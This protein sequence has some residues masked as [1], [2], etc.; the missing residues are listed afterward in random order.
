MKKQKKKVL[1]QNGGITLIA[2]IISVIILLILAGIT[3]L[4]LMGDNGILNN[5][6]KAAD[7]T[8][9]E[10]VKEELEMG[11]TTCQTKYL[12]EKAQDG[13]INKADYF[14]EEK[15]NEALG[16]KGKISE[17]TIDEED[18]TRVGKYY[19]NTVKSSYVFRIEEDGKVELEMVISKANIVL[20]I[21][22]GTADTKALETILADYITGT[23]TWE[24][25]D[26]SVAT[27]D[28][29]GLVT[30]VAEGTTEV[31]A[32]CG[33]YSSTCGITVRSYQAGDYIEYDVPYTDVRTNYNFTAT[34]GWRF[35]GADSDGNNLL[36]STGIPLYMGYQCSRYSMSVTPDDVKRLLGLED[37]HYRWDAYSGYYNA[38]ALLEKFADIEF[39][40]VEF[41][42]DGHQDYKVYA[43]NEDGSGY[44]A[45]LG[46]Y[47]NV[48]G[49][50]SGKL[51]E[52]GRNPL[53]TGGATIVRA[54]TYDEI[55][56][57]SEDDSLR[58]LLKLEN[59]HSEFGYYSKYTFNVWGSYFLAT[60][61][62]YNRFYNGF[63]NYKYLM[64]VD[65]SGR[66][67]TNNTIAHTRHTP[68]YRYTI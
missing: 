36:I 10:T 63:D 28:E 37:P 41:Y 7:K 24:S 40:H 16:N 62:E 48:G 38:A 25:L 9:R 31:T 50:D 61:S 47:I 21:R 18:G 29:N 68:C 5:S 67:R 34:N 39:Y 64:L 13:S 53:L 60:P 55:D 43:Y 20:L 52:N 11:Y 4:I 14:T 35:L 56:L 8:N 44:M 54:P 30:A 51:F 22:N 66:I 1:K 32:K 42:G 26:T 23:V 15:M 17:M 57:I 33:D 49:V 45:C 46:A 19:S 3:I 59:E 12:T 27:V 2:L 6:M 65:S 58:S